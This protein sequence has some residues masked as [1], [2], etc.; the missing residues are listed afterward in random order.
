MIAG[1]LSVSHMQ[2]A[3]SCFI[4]EVHYIAIHIHSG[5]IIHACIVQYRITPIT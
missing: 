3:N 1:L 4:V 5:L 2:D